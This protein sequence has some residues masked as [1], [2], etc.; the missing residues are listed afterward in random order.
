MKRKLSVFSMLCS[1]TMPSL[2]V[3]L[4]VLAA[5]NA[6]VFLANRPSG[7][8]A[9][10]SFLDSRPFFWVFS[11]VYILVSLVL[12]RA[13]CDRSGKLQYFL[14]RLRLSNRQIYLLHST[15]MPFVSLCCSPWR[16]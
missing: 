16:D 15:T 4:A 7:P 2:L 13:L 14:S 10:G 11:G 5:G 12:C 3:L 9:V 8:E 6:A 1:Y